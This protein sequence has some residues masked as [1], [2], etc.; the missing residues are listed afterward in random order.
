MSDAGHGFEDDMQAVAVTGLACRFPGADSAEEFWELLR[1]G[2][3]PR[4]DVPLDDLRRAGRLEQVENGS[5]IA[6]R[7]RFADPSLFDA[8]YF[9]MTPA[10]A[11]VTDPQQRFL[12]E[13][14][15]H[16]LEDAGLDPAAPPGRIGV[17]LGVNISDYLLENLLPHPEAV[18]PLGFHRVLMGNDRGYT[19]TQLAYRLG[20]TGPALAVDCAC[21]SSLA[22]VHH[23]CRALLDYEADAVLAGGAAIN[24]NDIG[25][26]Y[27]EGGI[28][29]PD[30][31]CRPF[32]A[33]AR[34]TVFSSGVGLVVLRRLQEALDDGD[35]VL[36][37]IRASALNNDGRDKSGYT[38]PSPQR[39]A[40]LIA[41]VHQLAGVTAER[42]S[43]VEAHGTGTPLGD[44]IEV[45]ALTQAFRHT[46]DKVGHCAIGSVKSNIG[47]L[48]AASGIAGLIKT[49]LALRHRTLPPSLGCERTNPHIDFDAS[50]FWVNTAL[51]PWTGP[52][53]LLAGVSSFG[54]GGTNAHLLVEEAPARPAAPRQGE[55]PA[56]ARVLPFSARSAVS[57]GLLQDQLLTRV[58]ACG[59][60]E[61]HD[62]AVA[63]AK[64]RTL[65]PLRRGLLWRGNSEP[66]VLDV[67]PV[68]AALEDRNPAFVLAQGHL[69]SEA[70]DSLLAQQPAFRSAV[71]RLSGRSVARARSL[72]PVALA[73]AADLGCVA[74]WAGHGVRPGAVVAD[75]GHRIAAAVV[76]G[77]VAAADVPGM[78]QGL[79]DGGDV[80]RVFA[81]VV[82]RPAEIPWYTSD[83]SEVCA[84][85]RVPDPAVVFGTGTAAPGQRTLPPRVPA[86]VDV[87][88]LPNRP[89][90]SAALFPEAV[91]V[92]APKEAGDG[93]EALSASLGLAWVAGLVRDRARLVQAGERGRF[94]ELPRYPFDR[95]RYWVEAGRFGTSSWPAAHDPQAGGGDAGL[96][97]AALEIFTE[98][99][100]RVD[101][102][103]DDDL[104]SLGGDSLLATRIVA[105]ARARWQRA[106]PL[107][108]FMEDPS[109]A[110]LARIATD[111]TAG[112]D[113]GHWQPPRTAEAGDVPATSLQEGFL[114]LGEIQGAAEAFNVPVLADLRGRLDLDALRGAVRDL[115]ARH[116]TLRTVFRRS[117]GRPVQVVVPEV[118]VE[119]PLVEVE[120]ETQLRAALAALLDTTIATD[121]APL[122]AA[123]LLR[124]GPERHVLAFAVHHLVADAASTGI[125][126]SDLY[127]FYD[128]RTGGAEPSLPE[129]RG[130]AAE[131]ARAEARWLKSA[132]AER[133][134]AFWK[135][136][137]SDV[138][139]PLELPGDQPRGAQRGYTGAKSV[140]TLPSATAQGVRELAAAESTTPF[141]VVLSTFAVLLSRICEQE[142]LVVGCPISGRHRIETRDL[143]GNFVNTLPIRFRIGEH[144]TFRSLV[145]ET[146]RRV[147]RS[148]DHQDLPFEVLARELDRARKD[149]RNDS[150]VFRVLCN[151]L[152]PG[153]M[154]PAPPSGL[155]LRPLPF[156]R[157]SS[158]YELSLDWWTDGDGVLGGRLIYDTERFTPA[159]VARWQEAFGH[160]LGLLCQVPDTTVDT[161]PVTPAGTAERMA[162]V[163]A[164]PVVDVPGLPVHAVF[165]RQAE[166]HPQR[167]AVSDGR[168][169]LAYGELAGLS[170]G[171][172]ELLASRG[173]GAGARV[174]LAMPRDA[175]L[176]VALLGVL[177][178][179]ATPVVYDLSHPTRRL[180]AIAE[181]CGPVLTLCAD[182]RDAAFVR[183]LGQPVMVVP[184]LSDVPVRRGVAAGDEV[185]PA[186]G[187][188][189]TYT[190]GT[191][192]KPKGIHFPHRA[193]ANL[194]HWETKGYTVASRWLQFAS[195]GFDAAFHETFAALCAGGSL[196]IVDDETRHDHDAFAEFVHR[197]EVEKAI[198][199]VSLMQAL[200]A[201]FEQN[202]APF[203]S[204][205]EIA[206]TGEQLRLGEAM[207]GFFE[208]LPECR[209]INN[210][211][212]AETHV[213]TS[214][215]FTG[216]PREWPRYAPIGKPLQNVT[217]D[218]VGSRADRTVPWGS[219]GE[220]VIA[221]PCVATG[222]VDDPALTDERFVRHAGGRRAYRSGDRARLLYSGDIAFLGRADQQ[223]KIRGV[224][225]ELGEIEVVMRED[226]GLADVALVVRGAEGDRCIDAY[227][228]PLPG[229]GDLVGRV[230]DRLRDGLPAALVPSTFTLVDRLPVNANGK[231]DPARLPAPGTRAPA[232]AADDKVPE[233][234]D[235]V[236]SGV[237]DAFRRILEAPGLSP[238]DDFF[239]AGGHSLLAT[240]LIHAVREAFGIRLS[241]TDFYQCGTAQRVARLVS[242]RRVPGTAYPDEELPAA[243]ADT[244]L[245]PGL[246]TLADRPGAD[247]QKTAVYD[248]GQRLDAARLT[249]AVSAL[250]E[251]Q[252]AL[253]A[254]VVDAHGIALAVVDAPHTAVVARCELPPHIAPADAAAWLYEQGQRVPIDP[255]RE[256]LV[257]VATLDLPDGRTLLA[258]TVHLLALDGRGLDN[259]CRTLGD[260][261]ARPNDGGAA[262]DGFLR[263]LAWRNRLP[264]DERSTD[265]ADVWQR[266]LA[267]LPAVQTT[268]AVGSEEQHRAQW[269]PD[270]ALQQALRARCAQQ[271]T[272]PFALHLTAFALALSWRAGT[273]TACPA[274]PL[275]GR[276]HQQLEKTVGAFAN[277]VPMPLTLPAEQTFGRILEGARQV[278]DQVLTI[279]G[280]PYADL[281]ATRPGLT[282]FLDLPEVFNYARD[283]DELVL[284]GTK[285][286]LEVGPDLMAPGRRVHL[287]VVD[288][289]QAFRVVFR[290]SGGPGEARLLSLYRQALYALVFEPDE[291]AGALS[292]AGVRS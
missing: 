166:R 42:I 255:R 65:H 155:E 72:A 162:A 95:R 19:A 85:G 170:G 105:L 218:I 81:D 232:A 89:N 149:E 10:E 115:V 91:T 275:D 27:T 184:A 60:E 40:E 186:V 26:S 75:E 265:A 38:A 192:G 54:V 226:S 33:D 220:L 136:E 98:A 268:G 15:V 117:D 9:D 58:R 188:Y 242:S 22:A 176:V 281:A 145:R 258:V 92:C 109:P 32:S 68:D 216:P 187:A 108:S 215:A 12:L 103:P 35:R 59:A 273:E 64:R 82:L 125:L 263:Y 286:L 21:S 121:R 202:T 287:T 30:A 219:I 37:V 16:A 264:G 106:V 266:L 44:P 247:R 224:R 135:R 197:H 254:K 13:T 24:P 18:E 231:V 3:D 23:A 62:I 283:D 272:T 120:D 207:V 211:G 70:V 119:V 234:D 1:D 230:R 17:Y 244:V 8:G 147:A 191:T 39:Q 76:C 169:T 66:V 102:S 53:P 137:L 249:A 148:M 94:A 259:L 88:P 129:I 209:L 183:Q 276:S 14:A 142:D 63:L 139:A 204:L 168:N 182:E 101:V 284:L 128:Q 248:T 86:V 5:H 290:H 31:Y 56:V 131:Y 238:Q 269:R 190:S 181:H 173:V 157:T 222:Y 116:E 282:R 229:C 73:V 199:P 221:G 167:V 203:G 292:P 118:T 288:N 227:L 97:R 43:Y 55:V 253:R 122:F 36:A 250:L 175:L 179:G 96:E 171:L 291:Y 246:A 113:D 217:L 126:L 112:A 150:A 193:L 237:L 80:T 177:R 7:K 47:H 69:S 274:V 74:V 278:V 260:A 225:V 132:E 49:V 160:L 154:A 252:T 51:R 158:P 223:V 235:E 134:I 146:A 6:V 77:A 228:V 45:S 241:I 210:Y 71:E 48:D 50:P 140:F 4:E 196:H 79:A 100:G 61:A 90:L 11:T 159:T 271:R 189:V 25:Y 270:P 251:W 208:R 205:R 277:V 78:L 289:P 257:R 130:L 123:R 107:G 245:P 201:R 151:M 236:L 57:L 195:F 67:R 198:V 163:L 29:S 141:V 46:S 178:A 194:V 243:D 256:P 2:V 20:L 110:G 124:T 267:P 240:R 114:F 280:V 144:Q 52:E 261:Y 239:D 185:D 180:S 152:D 285:P 262:D 165:V 172:A 93:P 156:E 279:S 200:A 34:G 174:G 111:A 206:V 164:G 84:A 127:A 83:G 214:F 153:G 212:P 213:V 161:C 28:S 99:L 143:I 133:Q 41:E 233:Y 104:F 138:P 87:L